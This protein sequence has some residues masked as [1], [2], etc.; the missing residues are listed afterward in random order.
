M[1]GPRLTGRRVLVVG[2]G[3]QPSD[4]PDAPVGNGRAIAVTAAREGATVVCADRD[5]SAADETV[6]WVD[7]EGGVATAL[8]GDIT[9]EEDCR[10]L[11]G[12]AADTDPLDGLVLN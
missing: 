9:V 7:G 5:R 1:S 12:G 10:A 3:T 11:V 2:A 6:R 8:V 4:D